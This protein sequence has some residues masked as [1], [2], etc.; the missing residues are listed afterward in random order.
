MF[1]AYLS[2]GTWVS[3]SGCTWVWVSKR[4]K[5]RGIVCV[6]KGGSKMGVGRERREAVKMWEEEVT[7]TFD[8]RRY[9]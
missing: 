8:M 6:R 4:E 7:H 2:H 5:E 3:E 9:E 1:T